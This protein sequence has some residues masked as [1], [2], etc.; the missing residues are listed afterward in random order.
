M[1]KIGNKE[2]DVNRT[3]IMGILN[4]TPDSFS[5]GGNFNSIDSALF[6]ADKMI[7]DG[8]DILDIGGEST[9]P[10]YNMI[11]PQEEIDRILPITSAI[12]ARFDIPIS[13]DTYKS[14]VAETV[15]SAG[16]DMINDIWRLKF[17]SSMGS[18]IAKANIPVCIMHNRKED[19]YNNLI[20][21][22]LEDLKES[23]DIAHSSGISDDNII[24][25]PGIGFA[26]NYE[27]NLMLINRLD[28]LH[29]LGYPLLLGTSRKSVIGTALDLPVTERLEGTLATT[30]VAYMKGA[31]FVRVHDVKENYRFIKMLNKIK[32]EH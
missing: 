22:V 3:H 17:D 19:K 25:D 13:V 16:A 29:Q 11:S 9:R 5:D 30:S 6:Q 18:V 2:F 1:M 23:I 7:K 24:I 14:Q 10:G 12:K 8:A 31:M 4:I 26:K 27:E 32:A 15:I 20:S 28:Q 21:D